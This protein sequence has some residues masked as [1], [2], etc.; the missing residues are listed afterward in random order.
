MG[1]PAKPGPSRPPKHREA[2]GLASA[3]SSVEVQRAAAELKKLEDQKRHEG[4]TMGLQ[5]CRLINE[6]RRKGFLDDEDFEDYVYDT[7][8][9]Y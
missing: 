2:S 6:K 4:F 8:P 1:P 9:E 7:E 5:G 3:N